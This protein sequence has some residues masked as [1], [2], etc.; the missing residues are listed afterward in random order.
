[1]ANARG[2]A[3]SGSSE[4]GGIAT[5]ARQRRLLDAAASV[6]MRFGFRKASMA[7][8]ARAAGVSRQGL[9]LHFATKEDLFR[10]A[11]QHLL[12]DALGEALARF[13]DE[14]QPL[15]DRLVGPFDSWLGQFAGAVTGDAADLE[16]A[17][18]EL[19]APLIAEREE[20]F[21]AA[22]TEALESS[23]LSTAYEAAGLTPRQLAETLYAT[24]RGLKHR[25][26]RAEFVE[27]MTV[28]VRA[29]CLPQRTDRRDPRQAHND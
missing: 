29:L 16:A 14:D 15:E 5:D 3:A 7:D 23:G 10:A 26:D 19:V 1:M 27:G 6:F 25:A 12:D 13:A 17:A 11:V 8:I 21:I 22:T 28:A 2:S 24:G 4:G 18:H 20:A 9:Y